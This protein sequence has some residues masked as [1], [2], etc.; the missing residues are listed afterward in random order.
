MEAA[1]F[2]SEDSTL[3]AV[4]TRGLQYLTYLFWAIVSVA[5][6]AAAQLAGSLVSRWLALLDGAR[7][8]FGFAAPVAGP[9]Y[10]LLAGFGVSVLGALAIV[11]FGWRAYR[12]AWTTRLMLVWAAGDRSRYS[13]I[14]PLSAVAGPAEL[15]LRADYL[16]ALSASMGH[17]A[18]GTATREGY[19]LAAQNVLKILET[20]IAHRAVTA[21]LVVGLNRNPLIDSASIVAAAL[22]LQLHVL[23]RLGKRPSLGTWIEML[24]RTT[25]S[26]FLNWYVSREDALYL[27]LAIKKTAWGMSAASDMAQQAAEALDDF[28]WDHLGGSVGVPGLSF[29]GSLAAKGIGVGAF[30]LRHIG[31]F[32][33]STADDLLQGVLAGG[34]LYYHGMALA[35]ECLAL[36][37]GHRASAGMNRTI[38]QAMLV[39][40]TPASRILQNQVRMLRNLLRERRKLAFGAAKNKVKSSAGSVWSSMRGRKEEVQMPLGEP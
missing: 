36:D 17:D 31:A 6:L 14:R 19:Q 24:K 13:R 11:A 27:K 26:L 21:G 2:A 28:D 29:I 20:E 5:A 7:R 23:T 39:A 9:D 18:A 32:I 3:A 8:S 33:E 4:R 40:C 38:S 22:E 34:I 10:L 12:R 37:A 30:G 15:A 1:E 35:A 16:A 25:A